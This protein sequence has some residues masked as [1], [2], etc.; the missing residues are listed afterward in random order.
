MKNNEDQVWVTIS[1][2]IN[3]GN[4]NS[5][6]IEAGLSQT[7]GENDPKDLLDAICDNVFELIKVKSKKYKKE[8]KEKPDTTSKRIKKPWVKNKFPDEEYGPDAGDNPND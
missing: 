3:L 1:R 7:I 4:Y 5:V 8:L 6:K 2:T